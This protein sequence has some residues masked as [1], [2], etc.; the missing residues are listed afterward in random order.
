[1]PLASFAWAAKSG[2]VPLKLYPYVATTAPAC[3]GLTQA[4][5]VFKGALPVSLDAP[6]L[7]LLALQKAPVAVTIWAG[8]DSGLHEYQQGK[9]PVR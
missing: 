9:L 8:P 5:H 1:L 2:I 3:R 6:N 7:L 4:R